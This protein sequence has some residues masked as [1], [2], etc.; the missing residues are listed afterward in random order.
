MSCFTQIRRFFAPRCRTEDGAPRWSAWIG[1]EER[2]ALVNPHTGRISAYIEH[3]GYGKYYPVLFVTP[4]RALELLLNE[5]CWV[6]SL[7]CFP[8]VGIEFIR[9][10]ADCMSDAIN[11]FKFDF[12]HG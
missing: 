7:R 6:R 8:R 1:D 4:W 2:A 3:D 11:V 12:D 5:S 9:I 10:K